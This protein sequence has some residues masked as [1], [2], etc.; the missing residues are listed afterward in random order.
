MLAANVRTVDPIEVARF[1]RKRERYELEIQEKAAKLP[2]LKA[3]EFRA[4]FGRSLLKRLVYIDDLEPFAIGLTTK[5][6]TEAQLEAYL[7]SLVSGRDANYD[8]SEIGRALDKLRFPIDIANAH[9]QITAYCAHDFELLDAVRYEE[10]RKENPKQI[11]HLR[12]QRVQPLAVKSKML[13]RDNTNL[14]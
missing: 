9:A 6:F 13:Q 8:P 3:V 1:L 2:S 14:R 5:N 4:S 12:L 11:I 7:R 10:F